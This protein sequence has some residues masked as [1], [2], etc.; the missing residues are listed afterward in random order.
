MKGGEFNYKEE[1]IK[2]KLENRS[3]FNLE[4]LI[5]GN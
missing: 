5:K 3:A 1:E 4:F 2:K